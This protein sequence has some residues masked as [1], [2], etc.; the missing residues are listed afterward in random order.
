V[1]S[2]DICY[3]AAAYKSV[4]ESEYNHTRCKKLAIACADLVTTD[5]NSQCNDLVAVGPRAGTDDTT[6][7]MPPRTADATILKEACSA[8]Y[9]TRL[10]VERRQEHSKSSRIHVIIYRRPQ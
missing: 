8:A 2:I 7:R 6:H 9:R 1:A 10:M 5:V 3:A 4:A